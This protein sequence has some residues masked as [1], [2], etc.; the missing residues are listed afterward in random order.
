MVWMGKESMQCFGEGENLPKVCPLENKQFRVRKNHLSARPPG[1]E[2]CQ[3][4]AWLRFPESGPRNVSR[5]QPGPLATK[6]SGHSPGL[7][8]VN[9]SRHT[10]RP[11]AGR[12]A[13][14]YC[15]AYARLPLLGSGAP[16]FS[17]HISRHTARRLVLA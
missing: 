4:Y 12:L 9:F 3:A 8:G 2:H 5:H 10:P 13:P 14:E 6:F 17:G 11:A 7:M 15:L 1:L 16:H